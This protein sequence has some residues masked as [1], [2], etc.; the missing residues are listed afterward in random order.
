MLHDAVHDNLTGLPNRE[1][2]T[3]RLGAAIL[4]AQKPG[5]AAPT[6]MV[7]DVDEF[8]SVN[9]SYGLSIGDSALLA[10][11]RR[12]ARDLRPGDTLARL[13]GDNFARSCSPN[14]ARWTRPPGSTPCMPRS[15][16]RSASANARS[17]CP[18]RSAPP[19]T[20]RSFTTRA[21]TSRRRPARARHRQEGGGWSGGDLRPQ[22][23]LHRTDRQTL[24]ND[25][26]RALERG[27]ISI[28]FRPIVRL[29]DRTVAG[30]Q[31]LIRWRH[32][33]LG[34][35]GEDEFLLRRRGDRRDRRHQHLCSGGDRA[36]SSRRG[37]RRSRSIRRSSPPSPPRRARC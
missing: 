31:S 30:F 28:L 23:A 6:V 19:T 25:M 22:D 8:R 9:D 29:E 35:L 13:G 14:P 7:I 17:R 3:D 36:G 37:R 32:P 10:V 20:T 2:F 24:E 15:P 12:L 27:E 4:L 11:A 18:C 34:V 26:R 1:L 33:R 5:G 21:A 16:L